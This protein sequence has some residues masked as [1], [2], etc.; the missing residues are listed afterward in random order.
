MANSDRPG[1]EAA[2]ERNVGIEPA[3]GNLGP[4]WFAEE[5]GLMWY[6]AR[7]A[8]LYRLAAFYIDKI[9]SVISIFQYPSA[10]QQGCRNDH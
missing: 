5:G 1:G 9:L 4:R 8:D 6:S 10:L 3:S 2:N 7:L